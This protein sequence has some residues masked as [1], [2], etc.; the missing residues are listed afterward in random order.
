M[1][2]LLW[3]SRLEEALRFAAECHQGQTRRGGNIPYF[4]HVVAVAMILARD[5]FDDDTVI[6]ALLHDVV[7]DTPATLAEVA[8][9]F[10]S[11]VA[12]TVRDCS[13]VKND[14]RGVK[15]P[16]ID[17]KH[18]H[19]AAIAAAP[20]SARAVV[21]ADKLHNLISIESDLRQGLPIWSQFHAQRDQVLWYY[22]AMIEQCARDDPR[23]ARL[24]EA[25]REVLGRIERVE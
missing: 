15:R 1:I 6:A 10:G 19:I 24:G 11:G 8:D 23:L 16:W 22:H 9:R 18:D 14:E 4:A 25:C 7:E 17:R 20:P 12:Q 2:D 21:L 3:P 13:E 5:G